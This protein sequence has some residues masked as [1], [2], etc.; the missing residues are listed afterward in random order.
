MLHSCLNFPKVTTDRLSVIFIIPHSP[1][2]SPLLFIPLLTWSKGLSV[3]QSNQAGIV[4]FSLRQDETE[5]EIS[6]IT[7]KAN[8]TTSCIRFPK[9]KHLRTNPELLKPKAKSIKDKS[10]KK[11]VGLVGT[12]GTLSIQL[13]GLEQNVKTPCGQTSLPEHRILLR[14]VFWPLTVAREWPPVTERPGSSPDTA[15]YWVT[16]GSHLT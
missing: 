6:F 4:Y 9:L 3:T 12:E 13:K 8:T 16:L 10:F 7:C 15:S 11:S 2:P 14:S 1:S 5:T